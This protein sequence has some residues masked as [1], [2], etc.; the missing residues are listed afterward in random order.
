MSP[1]YS[2]DPTSS[3]PKDE[4]DLPIAFNSI[5]IY[6]PYVTPPPYIVSSIEVSIDDA[7]YN[8]VNSNAGNATDTT[9]PT[10]AR[11]KKKKKS[12][13]DIMLTAVVDSCLEEQFDLFA[14]ENTLS[15]TP[16]YETGF[17]DLR[18]MDDIMDAD[19]AVAM[20]AGAGLRDLDDGGLTFDGSSNAA[21]SGA[22]HRAKAQKKRRS[23]SRVREK[24]NCRSKAGYQKLSIAGES[25]PSEIQ[26]RERV[27]PDNIRSSWI[28]EARM[29]QIKAIAE[30]DI[31]ELPEVSRKL[32][33]LLAEWSFSLSDQQQSSVGIDVVLVT[34]C[35]L[36]RLPNLQAQLACWT[37]K[38]SIAIYLKPTENKH[39]AIDDIMS[40]IRE[41]K[42]IAGKKIF[43]VVVTLVEG[44]MEE[45]PYPIN[46]LR[47]IALLEA[48]RQHLRINSSLDKS[49]TLLVDVDFRPSSNLHE[50]L[51]SKSAAN[52]ILK[53]GK[54]VVCPAFES[55]TTTWPH[56][57][58]SLKELID[59]GQ[60]EGFHLSHFPQ[61]HGPTQ[62]DTF[63]EKSLHCSTSTN[64][65]M[66][67]CIWKE[68]YNIRYKE[69]FEPYIVMASADVPLYDERFQGYGL[70]KVSHLAS[71]SREKEGAFFVLPGVFLVA[72]AH[73]RSESW[74]K[75]YG[76]SQSDDNKFNQLVLK[77]LYY[78]FM[79]NLEAGE[80]PIV[81]ENTRLKQQLILQQEKESK[82]KQDA[83]NESIQTHQVAHPTKSVLCY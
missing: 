50:I 1:R 28:E 40:T 11:S 30:S 29:Q 6:P 56:T 26:N 52:S 42:K 74:G 65:N 33:F 4:E 69:L 48:Q 80:D 13:N 2:N 60:A 34:Q 24:A 14:I 9:R 31:F 25:P 41:A 47:N 21:L 22:R 82:Q 71:V 19:D 18:D 77:G 83:S 55:T 12:K 3:D 32:P 72:S 64:D 20:Y 73:E 10:A 66:E 8:T 23:M 45:E 27:W 57:T 7:T 54:V 58:R 81:S 35:S 51:H 38:A 16:A 76:K 53:E 63:W 78:N 5:P 44:C 59:K 43:D 79:K 67:E 61:G 70:N 75:I 46:Y 68:S 15:D 37:G 39:D 49:A 62:F 17:D 36:D